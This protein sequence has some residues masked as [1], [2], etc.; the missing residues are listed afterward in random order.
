MPRDWRPLITAKRAFTSLF[1]R[2]EVGSS[3]MMSFDSWSRARQ[4]AMSW[5]S[6]TER[7]STRSSR[8]MSKPIWETAWAAMDLAR[9]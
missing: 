3:M 4:T 2:A 8:S 6:A 7:F 9:R 5:R 1:V